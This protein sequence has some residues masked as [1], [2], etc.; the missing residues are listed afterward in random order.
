MSDRPRP[1]D[2][3]YL[4]GLVR[5]FDRPRY[6]ATLFAPEPLR[7]DLFA[8]YGF[9]VEIERIPDQ[10]S[11]PTLG[12]IRLQWW[13]DSIS[14]A[15]GGNDTPALRALRS[16]ISRHA[17]PTAP[18]EA[19]IDARDADL[20]SD[21][22]VTLAELEQFM[23]E[24]ESSLFELGAA[25]VGAG[26]GLAERPRRAGLAY[27]L[28]R[29]LARFPVDRA[30]ARTIIPSDI[31][32]GVGLAPSDVFRPDRNADVHRAILALTDV[33][34]S[35]LGAARVQNGPRQAVPV[36]LPTVVVEPL[37]ARIELQDPAILNESASIPELATLVRMGWARLWG[38]SD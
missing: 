21:P 17:L 23:A 16:V 29:R 36:F 26:E 30:K 12:R 4:A 34:R 3:A 22:P 8:L 7:A 13:R 33:A 25:V 11:D 28:A 14:E 27:G 9:A 1:D 31:L 37:L 35:H 10:V 18:F 19:L 5:E 6:Y 2:I 20:Y 15:A 32:A 24:T 38:R